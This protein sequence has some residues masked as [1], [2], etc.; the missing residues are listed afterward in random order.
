MAIIALVVSVLSIGISLYVLSKVASVKELVDDAITGLDRHAD[1][2]NDITLGFKTL[3]E[4]TIESIENSQVREL[5]IHREVLK[6]KSTLYRE[7]CNKYGIDDSEE[8]VVEENNEENA[9]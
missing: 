4:K 1:L 8:D 3:S 7:I 6:L 9:D 5:A 2:L